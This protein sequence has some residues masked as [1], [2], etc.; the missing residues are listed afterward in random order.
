M[1]IQHGFLRNLLTGE[2]RLEGF[3]IDLL[4]GRIIIEEFNE[5]AEGICVVVDGVGAEVAGVLRG[6]R[7]SPAQVKLLVPEVMQCQIGEQDYPTM[8][9]AHPGILMR[10]GDGKNP[11]P[12]RHAQQFLPALKRAL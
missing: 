12:E 2:E 4:E 10:T 5:L 9:C 3:G 11:W 1:V 7:S 6:I 8:H